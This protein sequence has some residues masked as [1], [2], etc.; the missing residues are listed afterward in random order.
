MSIS[1]AEENRWEQKERR[2]YFEDSSGLFVDQ[3]GDSFNSSSTGKSS[4]GRLGDTLNV[5]PQ[6][7]TVTWEYKNGVSLG[8]KKRS[9]EV[10]RQ[11]YVWHRPCRDLFH[12]SFRVQTCWLSF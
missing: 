11:A 5:I 9:D 2:A 4:N 3:P 7:L 6:D 8:E 10:G 12:R 1:G